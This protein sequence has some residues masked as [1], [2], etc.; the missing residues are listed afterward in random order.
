MIGESLY[1]DLYIYILFKGHFAVFNTKL[2]IFRFN[3]QD[4]KVYEF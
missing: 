2:S 1:L 4:K 3:K